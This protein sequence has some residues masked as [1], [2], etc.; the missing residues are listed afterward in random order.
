MFLFCYFGLST[1]QII[2]TDNHPVRWTTPLGLPVVQPYCRSERHL[3]S[4]S[5]KATQSSFIII[6]LGANNILTNDWLQIR[7]SLQV[8][9]LQREGNTVKSLFSFLFF[10]FMSNEQDSHL[11]DLCTLKIFLLIPQVDV[12]KQRTAFPPNFVHSLDGTHM[13][14]TAVACREA[15]LNFAG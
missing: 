3:V 10:S 12:R 7:T 5:S 8:L 14:M 4:V 9:A 6:L 1:L 13:M 11:Y 2:A 15:G